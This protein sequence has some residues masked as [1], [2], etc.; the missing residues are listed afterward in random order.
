MS[1][2]SAGVSPRLRSQTEE[3]RVKN[4]TYNETKLKRKSPLTFNFQ[5]FV[6]ELPLRVVNND[7]FF[8]PPTRRF[9]RLIVRFY[10]SVHEITTMHENNRISFHLSIG[11]ITVKYPEVLL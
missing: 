10:S 7:N 6:T 1:I 11:E 2:I 3:E 8:N 4:M 9:H 5:S